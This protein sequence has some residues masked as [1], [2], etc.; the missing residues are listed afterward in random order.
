MIKIM[1]TLGEWLTTGGILLALVGVVWA[2][3]VAWTGTVSIDH[4]AALL[5]FGSMFVFAIGAVIRIASK[6]KPK[7]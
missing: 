3:I 5:T 2:V 1:R 6:L 7:E 4:P